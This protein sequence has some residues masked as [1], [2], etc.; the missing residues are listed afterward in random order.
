MHEKE[1]S[2]PAVVATKPANATVRTEAEPVEPRA[3]AKENAPRDGM[4]RTPSRISMSPGLER[5]RQVAFAAS[6]PRWEP[7]ALIGLVRF[8]AGGAR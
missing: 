1:K 7:D 2:D 5:V 4:R 8:C 3:G 6:H